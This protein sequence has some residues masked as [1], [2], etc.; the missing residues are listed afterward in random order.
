VAFEPTEDASEAPLAA[1]INLDWNLVLSELES[2]GD[3][4]LQKH[5][6]ER[7]NPLIRI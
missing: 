1:A 7:I 4:I 5:L 2:P 3:E 6:K